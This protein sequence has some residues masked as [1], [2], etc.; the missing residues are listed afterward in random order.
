MKHKLPHLVVLLGS[1]AGF[2]SVAVVDLGRT[3]P[4]PVTRVHGAIDEIA[5]GESCSSCHGGV[6][7]SMADAC[8]D[9]HEAIEQH[10]EDGT[11]L[12]GFLSGT[13]VSRCSNCHSEH[14]G[15]GFPMVNAQSFRMAGV[16]DVQEFDHEMIGFEMAGKHLELACLECHEFAEHDL[17]PKGEHRFI[18]LSQ[19]CASCHDDPHEGTL[20]QAC[21]SCHV[22]TGFEEQHFPAHEEIWPLAGSHAES[23]CL[24]CHEPES[25][26]SLATLTALSSSPK[27]RD[28]AACHES[29]HRDKFVIGNALASGFSQDASCTL[30][31]DPE[32]HTFRGELVPITA[33]Q[34]AQSGF[35]LGEPHTGVECADCHAPTRDVFRERF[36][37]RAADD[38]AQCH[39]TPHGDQFDDDPFSQGRCVACHETTHFEPHAVSLDVHAQAAIELTGAHASIDCGECHAIADDSAI[40][41]FRGTPDRC[42]SCH[43][44]AHSG[45]FE[46]FK[47]QLAHAQGGECATC[48]TTN[49]FTEIPEPGFR[50]AQFTGFPV[51]GAH[52][53][54]RCESCH[55]RTPEPDQH[56]RTFGRIVAHSGSPQACSNCHDDPHRGQFDARNLPDEI[57]GRRGCERCHDSTSFRS[58]PHGFDH[59]LWTGFE[60]SGTHADVSCSTCHASVAPSQVAASG[61]RTWGEARGSACNDCHADPHAGQFRRDGAID[62]ARCHTT[63]R[64]F[65]ELKFRHNLDSSFRLDE[66]HS[67]LACSACHEPVKVGEVEVVRYRPLGRECS[68]CHAMNQD[69]LRRPRRGDR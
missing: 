56:G 37:G 36:P 4:G 5:R 41:Q 19:N 15:P 17:V 24:D 60:L 59:G 38:C 67:A 44:D 46:S 61:G 54:S 33:E 11:G 6:F 58:L 57:Q 50:H 22:Q 39:D 66:T 48:H 8:L 28:C 20:Q 9:C 16:H 43:S 45:Y 2:L 29:P 3:S 7:E 14:N 23:T 26:F 65:S 40:R 27:P 47:A 53:Q 25:R 12:H 63:A 68:S 51:R 32:V 42:E 31:H 10:I 34:H 13:E 21:A 35:P 49:N 64:E 30:C 52:A 69:V 18:G 62:C 1:L 55:E